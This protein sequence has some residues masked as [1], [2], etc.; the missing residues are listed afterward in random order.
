MYTNIEG[1]IWFN[2]SEF[3]YGPGRDDFNDRVEVLDS[4]R[5][6]Q[7]FEEDPVQHLPSVIALDWEP[8]LGK[9]DTLVSLHLLGRYPIKVQDFWQPAVE[10]MEQT[11][12]A[13]G[14]ENPTDYIGS[15]MKRPISGT[16]LWSW[17]SYG[18]AIDLDYGGDTDGDGD[19]TIDKNPH[20]HRPIA[21]EDSG[22]GV[23]WQILEHQVRA[24]EAIRTNNDK[25]VWRWLGWSIGDTMH[26]EPACKPDDI[27][28]GIKE[29]TVDL[30]RQIQY[31]KEDDSGMEVEYW[32]V[33]MIEA[34]KGVKFYGSSNREFVAA[35][36]PTLTFKVWD[37]Q[38]T[39]YLSSWT[40]RNSY[41]VGPTE[42]VMIENA[43][44]VLY[45]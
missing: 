24:V 15:Y 38:M 18:G 19:P 43:I 5:P 31:V 29:D 6:D 9:T 42:R 35:E 45:N 30:G 33:R 13:N 20:I 21:S 17:H 4:D 16:D 12:V 8:Y 44:S 37:A 34:I 7:W 41:G 2:I 32:Q 3:E 27:E 26:F 10:A 25:K 39:A 40:R 28:T 14:Y 22:F 11:L 23:Q 36:A 1:F